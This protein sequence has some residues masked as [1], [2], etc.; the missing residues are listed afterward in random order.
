MTAAETKDAKI[1]VTLRL[2]PNT[3]RAI[4]AEK[5]AKH[6]RTVTATI[7]RLLREALDAE[8]RQEMRD[9]AT[10]LRNVVA[11]GFAQ[12]AVLALLARNI[13]IQSPEDKVLFDRFRQTLAQNAA[14]AD[15]AH[16]RDGN[17]QRVALQLMVHALSARS[18]EAST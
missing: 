12:D 7:E 9:L 11:H 10:A 8:G 14:A 16:E 18:P 3:Y 13:A 2:D 6:E 1:H 17:L 4:L 15:P 5:K